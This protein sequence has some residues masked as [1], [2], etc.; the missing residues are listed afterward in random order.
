MQMHLHMPTSETSHWRFPHQ[1]HL[2]PI[3]LSNSPSFAKL[4]RELSLIC[5]PERAFGST[6][7]HRCNSLR[8][9]RSSPAGVLW[10]LVLHSGPARSRGS[11]PRRPLQCGGG[12][13]FL[14]SNAP[15]QRLPLRGCV[16]PEGQ[17]FLICPF[18]QV[19]KAPHVCL[20]WLPLLRKLP[21][22]SPWVCVGVRVAVSKT[23]AWCV[24]LVRVTVPK[25]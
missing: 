7:V 22:T 8:R 19:T 3:G 4:F 9:E 12:C 2:F 20:P 15:R 13:H 24:Y 23:R 16:C 1:E 25:I 11:V 21:H 14:C 17:R 6:S 5:V 10:V 18:F